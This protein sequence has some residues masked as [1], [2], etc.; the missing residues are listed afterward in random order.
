MLGGRNPVA[1]RRRLLAELRRLRGSAGLTQ[2]EVSTRL[3]WSLSKV[4]R[5]E[6]GAVG[7]SITDLGALLRLYGVTD[8]AVV[9]SLSAAARASREKAWWDDYRPHHS[10]ELIDFIAVEA[11]AISMS[12]YQ[13]FVVPGILQTTE[14]IRAL[15]AAFHSTDE[16]IERSVVMR[17]QRRRLLTEEQPL[18]AR[19]ILDEA[20]IS[21]TVG[22]A[23]TM[24]EQLSFLLE[25]NELPNVSIQV[26]AFDRGVTDGMQSSFT[27][28]ELPDQ[29]PVAYLDQPGYLVL[30][31]TD[32][33]EVARYL[34]A[35][36]VLAGPAYS[37]P[38]DDLNS[39]IERIRE[40]W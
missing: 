38:A 17:T 26:T 15:G 2:K 33:N 1:E 40:R 8:Q 16:A 3:E 4:I 27:L 36:D 35:F 31:R 14:Y 9:D 22:S 29:D 24:R 7:I 13:A 28:F 6:G 37:S 5:I 21:R 10:P 30:A 34:D 19:F 25:L 20:S 23:D 32:P 12:E 18:V 39:A 11:S